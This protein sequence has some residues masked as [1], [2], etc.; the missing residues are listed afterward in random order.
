MLPDLPLYF[1][2]M[3]AWLFGYLII[4]IP[5]AFLFRWMFKVC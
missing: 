1:M 4:A 5:V 2:S 3:D